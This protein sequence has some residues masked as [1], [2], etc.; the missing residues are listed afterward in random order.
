MI[1]SLR[2]A[3]CAL[4][5]AAVWKPRLAWLYKHQ[6]DVVH[7][8]QDVPAPDASC[9]FVSRPR[10][11][12]SACG[13]DCLPVPVAELSLYYCLAATTHSRQRPMPAEG[14]APPAEC[15][16]FQDALHVHD[17]VVPGS[18]HCRVSAVI[19]VVVQAL[20]LHCQIHN[21]ASQSV[22][23]IHAASRLSPRTTRQPHGC[24]AGLSPAHCPRCCSSSIPLAWNSVWWCRPLQVPQPGYFCLCLMDVLVMCHG[25]SRS[26]AQREPSRDENGCRHFRRRL[27]VCPHLADPMLQSVQH[28]AGD[29]SGKVLLTAAV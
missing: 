3:V 10:A 11:C 20:C 17:S 29:R 18:S 6:V 12:T 23:L 8:V 13:G 4:P 1:H 5:S 2:L 16:R 19:S 22:G 28:G 15:Q 27:C 7:L 25:R 14:L 26:A 9:S 24:G 21:D